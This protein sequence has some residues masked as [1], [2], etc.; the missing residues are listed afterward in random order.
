MFLFH[1]MHVGCAAKFVLDCKTRVALTAQ[2]HG[3]VNLLCGGICANVKG[4]M[5]CNLQ[6]EALLLHGL[7]GTANYVILHVC[8]NAAVVES[9][10]V[11]F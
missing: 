2:H 8:A 3:C 10:A 11:Q 1:T 5:K 4:C 7:H 6:Q 9:N